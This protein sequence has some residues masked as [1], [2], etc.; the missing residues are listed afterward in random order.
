LFNAESGLY[1]V[2]TDG[3]SVFH[4]AERAAFIADFLIIWL[5]LLMIGFAWSYAAVKAYR[6]QAVTATRQVR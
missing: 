4:G 1:K 5:P 3:T 6:R 2:A